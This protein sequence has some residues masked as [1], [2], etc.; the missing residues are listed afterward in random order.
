MYSRCLGFD[1]GMASTGVAVGH[2][3]TITVEPIGAIVMDRGHPVWQDVERLIYDWS[4]DVLLVGKPVRVDGKQQA[5][6][7]RAKLFCKQLEQ[8]F[9][10][11]VVEVDERFSTVEARAE[12]F[13][14]SGVR[15]LTKSQI[16]AQSAAIIC[17]QWLCG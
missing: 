16:D 13:A 2:V 9:D 7:T 4:P 6:A 1:Y 10:L 12:I 14:I 17:H 3:A 5:I 11:P 8:K 15:G